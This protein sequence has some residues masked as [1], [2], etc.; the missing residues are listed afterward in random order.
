M[1]G[2]FYMNG[3]TRH[4]ARTAHLP[5]PRQTECRDSHNVAMSR[6]TDTQS[7]GNDMPG[8]EPQDARQQWVLGREEAANAPLGGAPAVSAGDNTFHTGYMSPRMGCGGP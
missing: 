7:S 5:P 1:V 6:S 2:S 3:E 8:R 4:F